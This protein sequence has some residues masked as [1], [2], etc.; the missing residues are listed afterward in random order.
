MQNARLETL[1]GA[2]PAAR[3][4]E[5][6]KEWFDGKEE[7]RT[8][9]GRLKDFSRNGAHLTVTL[10]KTPV[11]AEMAKQLVDEQQMP[12]RRGRRRRTQI[13]AWSD[14]QLKELAKEYIDKLVLVRKDKNERQFLFAMTDEDAWEYT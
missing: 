4:A 12:E 13:P 10:D 9:M 2:L 6:M 1:L 5:V 7:I 11:D 3:K 14:A 8:S